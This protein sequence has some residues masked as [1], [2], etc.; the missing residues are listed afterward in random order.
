MSV[1]RAFVASTSNIR[2]LLCI[3]VATWLKTKASGQ[4]GNGFTDYV[5]RFVYRNRKNNEYT[6][7]WRGAVGKWRRVNK[8]GR[9]GKNAQE[10]SRSRYWKVLLK[11]EKKVFF[12]IFIQKSNFD[13]MI[14]KTQITIPSLNEIFYY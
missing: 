3:A 11:C 9:A 10:R 8:G 2:R 13:L 4:K 12:L 5:F 14:L 1:W 6:K 7:V